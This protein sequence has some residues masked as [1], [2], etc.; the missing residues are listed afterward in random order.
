MGSGGT[1]AGMLLGAR[2][3]GL[4]SRIWAVNVCDTPEY[5]AA[6]VRGIA[7][8]FAV[9]FPGLAAEIRRAAG[10]EGEA[11]AEAAAELIPAGEIRILG[12]YKGP[13]YGIP[14]PAVLELIREAARADGLLL[15]PAYTGKAFHALVEETRRGRFRKGER[16][17]FLHT[18]GIFSLFPFRE[19]LFPGPN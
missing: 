6:R 5:F 4:G 18:G 14:S 12:D 19:E 8:E 17:L 11:A 9:R 1:L 13:R 2:R 7:S 15:D 3:A 10:F 16:V